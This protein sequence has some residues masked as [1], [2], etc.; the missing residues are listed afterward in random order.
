MVIH[1]HLQPCQKSCLLTEY[2]WHTEESFS[3]SC[4]CIL[5]WCETHFLWKHLLN[6]EHAVSCQ[7]YNLSAVKTYFLFITGFFQYQI[8]VL[9]PFSLVFYLSFFL[10]SLASFFLFSFTWN[11]ALHVIT[12]S[13]YS[14]FLLNF[15]YDVLD[16]CK[17][18]WV[19][20]IH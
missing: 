6:N 10:S 11:Q 16:H 1:C 12:D 18:S 4:T 19:G 5:R 8:Y 7:Y 3:S 14:V 2:M 9:C 20:E 17:I 13:I 15:L